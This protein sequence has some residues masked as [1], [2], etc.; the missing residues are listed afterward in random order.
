MKPRPTPI[1]LQIA[2]A[3]ALGSASFGTLVPVSQAQDMMQHVDLSSAAFTQSEM[4]RA[5]LEAKIAG[6]KEG[7]ILDLSAKSLNGLDLTGLDLRRVNLQSARLNKTVFKDA[8]LDGVVLDQAWA[9]DADFTGASFKKGSLFMTQ[10]IGAK[11]D[12]ADFSNARVAANMTRASLKGANFDGANLAAD[13][14]N[15]SMGLM[16]GVLSSANLEGASFKDANMA[17]VQ[18]EYA[19]LSGADLTG[20]DLSGSEL[21]GA[22]FNGARVAGANFDNADVNSAR[23][24]GLK[25]REKALNFEK[26]KNLDRAF[27]D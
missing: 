3:A 11:L 16:R 5:E 17:R 4:T 10:M 24:Q 27:Q 8:N 22:R 25:D 6:L 14:T 9:L 20:A 18:M 12:G 21:A 7:E 23:L 15:Q 19:D 26:A 1:I 13:M 2:F